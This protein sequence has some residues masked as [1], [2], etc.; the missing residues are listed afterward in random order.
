MVSSFLIVVLSVVIF[1]WA[2]GWLYGR[3]LV[4]PFSVQGANHYYK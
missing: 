4:D 3:N 2:I 1:P